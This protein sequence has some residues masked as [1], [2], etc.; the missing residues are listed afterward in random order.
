[1]TT[2]TIAETEAEM[3]IRQA[4]YELDLQRGA[5][6]FNIPALRRILEA[7]VP[8][9]PERVVR[10]PVAQAS[11]LLGLDDTGGH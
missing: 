6:V 2:S 8:R 10:R 5:G 3:A 4:L 11:D 9:E 7:G 1:M